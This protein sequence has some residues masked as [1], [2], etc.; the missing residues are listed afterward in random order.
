MKWNIVILVKKIGRY[1][2]SYVGHF[3]NRMEDKKS[4]WIMNLVT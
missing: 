1:G 4:W 3:F 2:A